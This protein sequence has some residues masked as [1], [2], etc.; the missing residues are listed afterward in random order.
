[1]AILSGVQSCHAC[2]CQA[3][4][5][6]QTLILVITNI[7]LF[8]FTSDRQTFS[9]SL[10]LILTPSSISA[11]KIH[12]AYSYVRLA[13]CYYLSK[14]PNIFWLQICES[15]M[16]KLDV[17]HHYI[18]PLTQKVG[19]TIIFV[20][21]RE[22]AR[23]LH[24]SVSLVPWSASSMHM[25]TYTHTHIYMINMYIACMHACLLACLLVEWTP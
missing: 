3:D 16:K 23:Q 1:M 2:T 5:I 12:I 20:R 18:F 7:L 24:S 11:L 8:E 22:T 25:H 9:L 6:T 19:Q 15:P 21:T 17:L 10:A 4:V 14:I 13:P